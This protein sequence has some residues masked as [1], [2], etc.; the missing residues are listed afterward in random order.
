M[1]SA[2][3]GQTTPNHSEISPLETDPAKGRDFR[4]ISVHPNGEELLFTECVYDPKVEPTGDCYVLRYRLATKSLYRYALPTGYVY[5]TASLSPHGH[6]IVLS[7]VPKIGISEDAVRQAHDQSEIVHMKVDGTGFRVVP[8]AKGYKVGPIMSDDETRV[9]YWRS[10]LRPPGSKTFSSHFDVWEVD[11][12]TGQ[13]RLFAGQFKF[14]DRS[15]L[16]YL[17][18]DEML[19]GADGPSQ[20]AQAISK[21]WAKYNRSAIYRIARGMRALPEPT[22]TEVEGAQYPSSDRAGNLYFQGQRPGISLFRKD[23]HGEIQQ[24]GWPVRYGPG[25]WG[26]GGWYDL[27]ADPGGSFIAFVY[28]IKG[29]LARDAKR[30]LGL[31]ITQTSEWRD[32]NIPALQASQ[33]IPVTAAELSSN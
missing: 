16:Q 7:R 24:W 17:S 33:L 5:Q 18:Q 25:D 9:A 21:Y 27:V 10:T 20:Y 14:F 4:D 29:T 1:N 11:L 31:L 3:S 32:L 30:R 22:L 8:L 28:K 13:D 26:G 12:K 6:F 19:V 2:Q 23:R 15:G